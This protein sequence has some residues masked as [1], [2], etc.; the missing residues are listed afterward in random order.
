[1]FGFL[2]R[3]TDLCV[4]IYI[5]ALWEV[6][7]IST[8]N[9]SIQWS[10]GSAPIGVQ[11]PLTSSLR[12][13]L[14]YWAASGTLSFRPCWCPSH[15][16]SPSM[17]WCFSIHSSPAIGFHSCFSFTADISASI[18]ST[19]HSLLGEFSGLGLAL[20]PDVVVLEAEHGYA[21]IRNLDPNFCPGRGRT[22][23]LGI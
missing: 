20:A 14:G 19:L 13:F 21:W 18:R 23:D 12:E 6:L 17:S 3:Y 11:C 16:P 1:M 4:Y 22:S 2:T 10:I 8:Y 5:H 7:S 9:P 15:F